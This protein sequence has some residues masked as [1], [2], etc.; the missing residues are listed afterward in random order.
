MVSW[1]PIKESVSRE[2]E[3]SAELN[4]IDKGFKHLELTI[5]L[6]NMG[7]VNKLVK[8]SICRGWDK[9]PIRVSGKNRRIKIG[10]S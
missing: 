7:D 9:A 6:S 3:Q 1:K 8:G 2:R 4:S 10:D 5:A